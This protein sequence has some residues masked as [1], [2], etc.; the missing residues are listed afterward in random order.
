MTD[1]KDILV[2]NLRL[3]EQRLSQPELLWSNRQFG[4]NRI[5]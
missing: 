1:C 5:L 4:H 2:L 3:K